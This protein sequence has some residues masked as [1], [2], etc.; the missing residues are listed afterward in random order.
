M[1]LPKRRILRRIVQDAIDDR[2][3]FED[4]EIAQRTQ[5]TLNAYREL[6]PRLADRAPPLHKQD[7]EVL[8]QA[9][10]HAR[11]WRESLEDAHAHMDD[12]AL[13]QDLAND[14][15]QLDRLD[16]A[17]GIINPHKALSMMTSVSIFDL[18]KAA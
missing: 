15:K 2:L 14:V 4:P 6:L 10:I 18:R 13:K 11:Y 1:K 7:Y 16:D 8:K 5:D 17:L 9:S 12:K 3:C